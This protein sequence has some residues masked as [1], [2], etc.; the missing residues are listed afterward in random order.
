VTF[1]YPRNVTGSFD[2]WN[3]TITSE[4]ADV[5]YTKNGHTFEGTDV[6]S[7]SHDYSP[8]SDLPTT[9][10]ITSTPTNVVPLPGLYTSDIQRFEFRLDQTVNPSFNLYGPCTSLA[11]A[12]GGYVTYERPVTNS[13]YINLIEVS[14]PSATYT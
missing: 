14:V 2:H 1:E 12:N 11:K 9:A 4:N 8:D 13:P 7:E 6:D 3:D 10:P 5:I